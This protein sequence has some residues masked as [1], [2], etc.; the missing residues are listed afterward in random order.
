MHESLKEG[1]LMQ[2]QFEAKELT[3][4]IC[5]LRYFKTRVVCKHMSMLKKISFLVIS[6]I[7]YKNITLYLRIAGI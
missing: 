6:L 7:G 5:L 3:H 2:L 1:F 4:Y